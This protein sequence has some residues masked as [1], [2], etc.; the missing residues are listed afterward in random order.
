MSDIHTR[1]KLT[2]TATGAYLQYETFDPTN[3]QSIKFELD[4]NTNQAR[5]LA[6]RS[7]Y[8]EPA[9]AMKFLEWLDERGINY[10]YE[11]AYELDDGDYKSFMVVW[12]PPEAVD[13]AMLFKLT[14]G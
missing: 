3:W 1:R 11:Y 6:I 7:L 12:F 14:F 8:G 10:R 13:Q 9:P 5:A 4:P 2:Q